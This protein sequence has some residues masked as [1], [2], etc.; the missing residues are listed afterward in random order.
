MKLIYRG[1]EYETMTGKGVLTPRP[2]MLADYQQATGQNIRRVWTT[3]NHTPL[4]QEYCSYQ[5]SSNWNT[6]VY[7]LATPLITGN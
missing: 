7:Q 5:A 1:A 6:P 4:Q 2:D 3:D